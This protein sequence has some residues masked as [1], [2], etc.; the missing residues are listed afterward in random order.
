MQVTETISSKQPTAVNASQDVQKQDIMGKDAFFKLLIMQLR[1]QDPLNPMDDRE[2][3]AQLAQF[4]SLEQLQNLSQQFQ[5]THALSIIGKMVQATNPISGDPVSGV[6]QFVRFV[7]GKPLVV[8]KDS[9]NNEVELEMSQV[10][11]VE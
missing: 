8:I 9:K 6:V 4:S 5:T 11:S 1:N 2:F 10:L 3:I 7:D